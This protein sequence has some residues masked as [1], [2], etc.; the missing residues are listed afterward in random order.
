VGKES[1]ITSLDTIPKQRNS[2]EIERFNQSHEQDEIEFEKV[3]RQKPLNSGIYIEGSVEGND[4]IITVDTG[5]TKTFMSRRVYDQITE[6]RRPELYMN[7]FSQ[8]MTGADGKFI[9][10]FGRAVFELGL[11]PLKIKRSII[12]ADIQ[13]DILLGAD[14]LIRDPRGPVDLLLSRSTMIFDNV[15]I[16]LKRVGEPYAEV[17]RVLAADHFVV[18]ALSECIIDCF[19]EIDNYGNGSLRQCDSCLLIENTETFVEK[20]G[21]SVAPCLVNAK[22]NAT[23]QVRIL[24][25]FLEDKSIKQDMTVGL[26]VPVEP[27]TQ[28]VAE[29]E[30]PHL[31]DDFACAR[32]LNI[33]DN[34][35]SDTLNVPSEC[36]SN[37][38][39]PLKLSGEYESLEHCVRNLPS[40]LTDLY[41]RSVINLKSD[42]EKQLVAELLIE[43]QDTFSK[44]DNDVGRTDLVEHVIETGDARPVK[45]PPRRVPIAFQGEEKAAIEKLLEQGTIRPSTSPWA[46]PLVLVRKKDQTVRTCVDYR[47]VNRKTQ[48]D[49]F[50]LPRVGDCLD[51][52]SGSTLF[53]TMDITSAYNNVPVRKEDIPKTAFC[54]KYGGLFEYIYMP[55]GM[56]NSAATFQ[57]LIEIVL[58]SMQWHSALLYLDDIICHAQ[59]FKSHLL[60]LRE[61]LKRLS[62]AG[63]KLKPKKCA[64]FQSEVTFL[65][66]IVGQDGIRPNPDNVLKLVNWPTP[67][68]QTDVRGILGLANYYRRFVY[69]FSHIV[70]PLTELTAKDKPFIWS[71]ECQEAFDIVKSILTSKPIMAYPRSDCPYILDTDASDS[72]IGAILSQA[73]EGF[74]RVIAY[75]SRTLNKCERRYCVTDRELLAVKHFTEYYKYYLLG[76]HFTYPVRSPGLKMVI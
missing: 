21:M 30:N 18:P 12:V 57:R 54:T 8:P 47:L 46:S 32:R 22:D 6:N 40:Y 31:T 20:T 42:F 69:K 44:D 74:E 48:I 2:I 39:D 14:I 37:Q 68:N 16:P 24:N 15:E 59:E 36:G 49:S 52:L 65:G 34:F 63:L 29:A 56:C 35:E 10:R 51:A 72:A 55:F 3:R 41:E 9:S 64:F 43:Y 33:S 5:A 66:H 70:K 13:D 17:R 19:V 23:V 38:S 58:G 25:P 28:V 53:S 4:V 60:R 45:Q 73:Q 1:A 11:G 76:Q 67:Q 62:T 71:D 50:P 7:S 27:P 75:G 26:S 61:I